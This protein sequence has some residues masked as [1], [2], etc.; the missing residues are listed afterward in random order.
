MQEI[1]VILQEEDILLLR[2][3]GYVETEEHGVRVRI[4]GRHL[5]PPGAVLNLDVLAAVRMAKEQMEQMEPL[6]RDP[7]YAR[8]VAELA[9][10]L[11]RDKRP[12][13]SEAQQRRFLEIAERYAQAP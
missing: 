13:L 6:P 11:Y 8:D 9:L 12:G 5:Y 4:G 3:G 1:T 2:R 7:R 10:S